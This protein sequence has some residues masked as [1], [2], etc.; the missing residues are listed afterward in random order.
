VFNRRG[1]EVIAGMQQAENGRVVALG[2]TGVE[3]YLSRMA[4]E[5][6]GHSLAG[7]VDGCVGVLS[8]QVDGRGI[9]E[10]LC[11]VWTHGL[12]NLGQ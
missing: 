10:V 4:V 11:P 5:E 8:L 12:H 7:A 3:D 1:D 9:P 2:S 6:A